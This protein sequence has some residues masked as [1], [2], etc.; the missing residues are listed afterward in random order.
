MAAELLA[1]RRV[2]VS[3]VFGLERWAAENAA[4]IEPFLEKFNPVSESE[5]K[6]ISSL[7][8]PNKVLVVAEMPNESFSPEILQ[9][10]F[11][12]YLDGIQ[13]PGNLGTILRT[14]DWFGIPA[15]FCSPDSADAFSPK[16]VQASMGAFLRVKIWEIPFEKILENAPNLPVWGAVLEGKNIFEAKLPP[17]GLLVVGNEGRGVSPEVE[18]RLTHR[19][20]IPRHPNGGAE[21]LNAAV[22]AG[23]F[24][25]ALRNQS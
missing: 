15:V 6:K 12:F 9:T 20:S 1:Q 7:T 21:S 4:L 17:N 2:A 25:A 11:C 5:L 10:D 18:R 8:T 24:A 22:A 3:A 19:L 13:D 14:A 23:I 16:V